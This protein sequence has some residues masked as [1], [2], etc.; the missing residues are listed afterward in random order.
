MDSCRYREVD[1]T[2]DWALHISARDTIALFR[3]AAQ[4]MLSLLGAQPAGKPSGRETIQLASVDLESL[5][6]SW[7]EEILY[8]VE[9][10][11]VTCSVIQMS[12]KAG[13]EL[14]AS[15]ELTPRQPLYKQIKAV[16]FHDLKVVQVGDRLETTVVFDV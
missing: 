14:E 11:E 3:C 7:L 4:G 10:R 16:T 1:H 15:V 12:I 8:I 2:A 6:V 9:E 5:L 13:A